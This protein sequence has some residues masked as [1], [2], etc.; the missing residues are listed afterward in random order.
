M[1]SKLTF[2][3]QLVK[4]REIHGNT[5]GYDKSTYINNSSKMK[6]ICPIHGEFWQTPNKHKDGNGCKK[7]SNKRKTTSFNII[8]KKFNLIHNNKYKYDESTYINTKNKMAIICPIH[9][10][11]YQAVN[12]HLNGCGC[13]KCRSD[14]MK[15]ILRDSV[16]TTLENFKKIHGDKYKYDFSNYEDQDTKIKI[17]CP[18]HGEFYQTSSMHKSG[19][20]CPKCGLIKQGIS[21]RKQWEDVINLFKK[22][23]GN[24]YIYN[25]N[26]YINFTTKMRIICPIHGEFFQDP[27]NHF[28]GNGCPKCNESKGEMEITKFLKKYNIKF[29]SQYKFEDCKYKYLLSFDFYLPEY[30]IC[31]EYDGIQHYEFN[32]HFHKNINNF[33][34]Q[35]LR[36]KI[37]DNY[38]FVKKIK[39]LRIPH[40]DF[41]NIKTILQQ[42]LCK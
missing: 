11:F 35:Q 13:P 27:H 4:F 24:K 30:N 42:Y 5:Y 29:I 17:N 39:L 3:E 15:L 16:E 20:G 8:F 22:T 32:S 37:K 40:W 9:G 14:K 12:H 19:Q 31:I 10:K 18:L 28:Y 25:E 21:G 1:P 26:D 36:D 7:C 6:I 41:N 23:H 2:Q 33:K 34:E 38:C